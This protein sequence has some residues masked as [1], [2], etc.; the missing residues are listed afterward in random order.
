[1]IDEIKANQDK[2]PSLVRLKDEVQTGQAPRFH[3]V[4]G[5]LRHGNRLYIPNI[6]E[7]RQKIMQKA[8]Y[9]PYSV[10]PRATKMYYDI[11]AVYWWFGMKRDVAEF[12]AAYL[13]CQQIKFEHQRPTRL[14]QELPLLEWKWGHITMDF[15][16]GLSKTPKGYDSIWVIVE[17]LTKSAHF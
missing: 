1:M 2:D 7:L 11:K 6:D 14:L 15:V 10:H 9:A 5:V 12:V 17:R 4:K 8:H 13:T 3:V 16:V